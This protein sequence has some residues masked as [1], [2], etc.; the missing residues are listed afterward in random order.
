MKYISM[1][2]VIPADLIYFFSARPNPTV[3]AAEIEAYSLYQEVLYLK[4]VHSM[5]EAY[6]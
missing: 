4:T 3:N 2:F 5:N 6:Y 1:K